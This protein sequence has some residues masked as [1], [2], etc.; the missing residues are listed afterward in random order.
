MDDDG[1][2]VSCLYVMHRKVY[3]SVYIVYVYIFFRSSKVFYAPLVKGLYSQISTIYIQNKE[4]HC[5]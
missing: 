5:I 1:Y 4:N 2:S 3:F